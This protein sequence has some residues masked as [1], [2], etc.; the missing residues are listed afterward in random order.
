MMARF[1]AILALTLSVLLPN[2]GRAAPA[3]SVSN[4]WSRPA[5]ETGVVYATINNSAGKADALLS[6][7]SPVAKAVELHE[8]VPASSGGSM[9][10]GMGSTNM[11]SAMMMRPVHSIAIPANGSVQLKPGSYHIML[12][13]LRHDLTAGQV[14]PLTLHFRDAG[15][16]H[17]TSH[18]RS[19]TP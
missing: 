18:V 3:I 2:A 13:D 10:S 11:G 5:T 6:A 17:V 1:C 9:S 12:I 19:M 15:V 16:V 7:S 4:V 8:T 14:I